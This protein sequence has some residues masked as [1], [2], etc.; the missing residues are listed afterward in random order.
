MMMMVMRMR[1]IEVMI[2]LLLMLL[3]YIYI[4][5][6]FW[7]SRSWSFLFGIFPCTSNSFRYSFLHSFFKANG[8]F[9]FFFHH[10]SHQK[11]LQSLVWLLFLQSVNILLTPRIRWL[12]ERYENTFMGFIWTRDRGRHVSTLPTGLFLQQR[13]QKTHLFNRKKKSLFLSIQNSFYKVIHL[14]LLSLFNCK[15]FLSIL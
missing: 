12:K 6:F 14:K 9:F 7:E 13:G 2:L 4:T 8:G 15:F 5:F 10:S 1:T 11:T 3:I